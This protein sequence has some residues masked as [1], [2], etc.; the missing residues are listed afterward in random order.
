MLIAAL[1]AIGTLVLAG[2]GLYGALQLTRPPRC[3]FEDTAER[4]GLPQPEPVWM[5]AAD[6]VPLAGWLLEHKDAVASVVVCHGHGANKLTSLWA[7]AYLYPR[8]NV[9]LFDVRGHGE[10]GGDRTSVGYFER[11]DIGGAVGWL[12][13]RLPDLPI[14]VLGISMGGAAAILAAAEFPQ[15]AAVVA[16]SPFARLRSPVREAICARGY[17]RQLS[18]LLAWSVC[19]VAAQLGSLRG[20]WHD[21]IDV[22]Q[23]IAPRPLL[24]IHGEADDLIPVDNAYALYRRAGQP[25]ELWIVPEVGHA[26]VA[27]IEPVA[28][29]SRVLGFFERWLAASEPGRQPAAATGASHR[30]DV[31]DRELY[32]VDRR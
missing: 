14:G 26:R 28:Y 11:L 6:G 13:A 16:D 32:E 5:S 31:G 9:L 27:E 1:G 23:R 10:S 30:Q 17:P 29:G 18:P 22:V 20:A 24:L 2:L 8:F 21:P 12:A 3:D 25:C 4:W 15:I 7:A 19:T